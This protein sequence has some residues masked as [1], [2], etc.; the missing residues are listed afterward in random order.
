MS[1]SLRRDMIAGGLAG[2]VSGFV[3]GW[4]LNAQD[5]MVEVTGQI[6]L[7][8]AGAGWGLRMLILA[9]G[10]VAFGAIFRYQPQGYAAGLSNGLLFGLLAWIAIPL[11]LNPVL[12]GKGPTWSIE[13]G[14]ESPFTC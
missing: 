9:L 3:F 11:T 8:S 6:G 1:K 4:A 10:G 12:L 14:W 5:M 7:S 2:L 13:P